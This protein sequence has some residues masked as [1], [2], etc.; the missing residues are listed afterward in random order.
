MRVHYKQTHPE[1]L[2]LNPCR[3]AMRELMPNC[4]ADQWC[5]QDLNP[6]L[7]ASLQLTIHLDPNSSPPPP[8]PRQVQG[9][10]KVTGRRSPPGEGVPRRTHLVPRETRR[11]SRQGRGPS[12]RA[13][14]ASAVLGS[15]PSLLEVF[16]APQHCGERRLGAVSFCVCVGFV[17]GFF[18]VFLAHLYNLREDGRRRVRDPR[19]EEFP[20]PLP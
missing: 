1:F 3:K 14:H 8:R 17:C 12:T 20:T 19:S 11:S 6:R 13:L 10:V 9:G 4:T 16:E 2:S 5:G 18:N 7:A 15:L